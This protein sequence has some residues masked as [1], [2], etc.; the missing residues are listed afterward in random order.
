M[1]PG[2]SGLLLVISN[3]TGYS[4]H[5]E[6]GHPFNDCKAINKLFADIADD[7][8]CNLENVML[9]FSRMWHEYTT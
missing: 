3:N 2:T 4:N 7:P 9:F 5:S 8:I 6:L 1:I